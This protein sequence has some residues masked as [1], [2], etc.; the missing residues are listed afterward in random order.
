MDNTVFS[1]DP[2]L[3]RLHYSGAVQ[4][5][6]DRL[7]ALHRAQAYTIPFENFDILL[8]RGISLDPAVLYDKLVR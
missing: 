1:L 3:A 4:P 6:Q 8:G 7:E 2:Y 5:T